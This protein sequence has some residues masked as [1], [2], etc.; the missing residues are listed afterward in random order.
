MYALAMLADDTV[1]LCIS[2]TVLMYKQYYEIQQTVWC[3]TSMQNSKDRGPGVL[4]PPPLVFVIAIILGYFF[5][6]IFTIVTLN[7]YLWVL[8]GSTGIVLSV[9]V[10]CYALYSYIKAKTHIEPWQPANHLITT[11]LY[12]FSRNPI[13]LTFFVL[14]VSIGLLLGKFWIILL[15]IPALAVIQTYVIKREEAYLAK[16]FADK[17]I[18]YQRSVNRWL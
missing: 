13:Y 8:L 1:R 10:L 9:G 16:V 18:K 2:L 4:F 12:Q 7:S 11:G 5:D 3:K 6:R 15:A 17:Y 14:T